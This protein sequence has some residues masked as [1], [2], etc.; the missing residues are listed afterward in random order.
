MEFPLHPTSRFESARTVIRRPK[1]FMYFS[2][3]EHHVLQPSS[4]QS[5]GY[6]YPPFIAAPGVA[7]PP[8]DLSVGFEDWIKNDETVDGHLDA[9]L[10]M[11]RLHEEERM[12]DPNVD[13]ENVRIDADVVTWRGMMTKV[14]QRGVT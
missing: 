4:L 9:L 2:F 11:M 13:L 7:L 12:Q 3:D 8:V 10:E 14:E 6:Y 1:E 5:L